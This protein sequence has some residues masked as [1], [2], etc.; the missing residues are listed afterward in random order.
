MIVP[1]LAILMVAP[2]L[3][4][5][6]PLVRSKFC[7]VTLLPMDAPA[8]LSNVK[9]SIELPDAKFKVPRLLALVGIIIE[10]DVFPDMVPVPPEVMVPF[11]VKVLP[12]IINVP[13]VKERLST[14]ILFPS[15]AEPEALRLII[16]VPMMVDEAS[17]GITPNA[18]E[19]LIVIVEPDPLFKAPDPT[20][21]NP[22]M[23]NVLLPINK[24]PEVRV[25]VEFA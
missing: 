10:E 19:P 9:E 15:V 25:S 3:A 22:S 23:I 4:V 18:P 17:N 12:L 20:E 7:I 5:K 11:S 8:I 14:I 21:R 6:V 13:F 2:T 24:L 1:A 16:N